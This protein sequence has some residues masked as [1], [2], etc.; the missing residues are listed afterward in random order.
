[1]MSKGVTRY[2]TQLECCV[3]VSKSISECLL[4]RGRQLLNTTSW[5]LLRMK[6]LS[7]NHAWFYDRL[8][9]LLASIYES[10]SSDR[11]CFSLTFLPTCL[12]AIIDWQQ[13]VKVTTNQL[14]SE[15]IGK[16]YSIFKGNNHA[17][18]AGCV[19]RYAHEYK[20]LGGVAGS[21]LA[22]MYFGW[23][24]SYSNQIGSQA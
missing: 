17:W 16:K 1:M 9:P 12:P 15:K 19:D 23:L 6:C 20:Y 5:S 3:Y 10:R 7:T 22:K 24:A 2:L 18:Y 4:A 14:Q 8:T 13:L 11:V 21:V